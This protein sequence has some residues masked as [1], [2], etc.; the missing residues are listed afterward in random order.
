[1]VKR[2]LALLLA[3]AL[4]AVASAQQFSTG[5]LYWCA[6]E[7]MGNNIPAT[8]NTDPLNPG[9]PRSI[10]GTFSGSPTRINT[11]CHDITGQTNGMMVTFSNGTVV[12]NNCASGT[13]S[14]Y[15]PY[16][17]NPT[18]CLVSRASAPPAACARV[19]L[20]ACQP[21]S[22]DPVRTH[23]ACPARTAH[24]ASAIPALK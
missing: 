17:V 22:S 16:D 20:C 8:T 21:P 12:P 9:S 15:T 6:M 23:R 18:G 1:M 7:E 14:G 11:A 4:V 19:A 24:P 13:C 2:S 5:I 3:A 10:W